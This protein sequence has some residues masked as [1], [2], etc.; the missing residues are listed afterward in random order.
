MIE[1]FAGI[2]VGL[3][4][5]RA[6]IVTHQGRLVCTTRIAA[7]TDVLSAT[8]VCT[9]GFA[10]LQ[11]VMAKRRSRGLAGFAIAAVG[12]SPVLLKRNCQELKRIPLFPPNAGQ[13]QT[14]DLKARLVAARAAWPNT[15]AKAES[16]VDLTGF[17]VAKFTGT[18]VM[19]HGTA[20]DYRSAGA[21]LGLPTPDALP[22]AA[23]AG[24]VRA[25]AAK[26]LGVAS[27]IPVAVGCYDSTADI[28][29]A[30]FGPDRPAVIV[31]GSTLVMGRLTP[32]PVTDKSLRSTLH[33]GDGWFSGGWTNM[34]GSALRLGEQ[35]LARPGAAGSGP[36]P[37]VLPYFLGERAP[38][39]N[40]VASGAVL[41]LMADMKAG[42]VHRGILE[43]VVLSALDIA[44]RLAVELGAVG[45]WTVTGGATRN[46][47]L[48]QCLSDALG[49]RLDVIRYAADAVGP[50]LLAA[51]SCGHDITLPIVASWRPRRAATAYFKQRLSLYRR[52]HAAMLPL[53]AE[54]RTI[55]RREGKQT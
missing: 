50:A 42:D 32:K 23:I 15:F 34:A 14:D 4:G 31:I 54:L 6:S 49:A 26:S 24:K 29:A 13:N 45:N 21:S 8:E 40:R 41:G 37:L 5:V 18:A 30:G 28:A 9:L 44:D 47:E 27:G 10:A 2:D 20:V 33:L 51:R 22:A 11:K 25:R 16:C 53:Y 48:M 17:A 52:C 3:S 12:P 43:G 39:W 38:V 36:V 35:W 19:D 46:P 1:H 7:N 55:T